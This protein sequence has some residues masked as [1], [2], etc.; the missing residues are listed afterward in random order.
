MC[1]VFLGQ[2]IEFGSFYQKMPIF[3]SSSKL[4]QTLD[5]HS[6]NLL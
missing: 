5:F 2:V 4:G 3:N 6:Y 1:E